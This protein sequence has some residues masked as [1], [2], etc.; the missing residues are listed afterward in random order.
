MA[1]SLKDAETDR[2]A[3]EVTKLTGE[4]LAEGAAKPLDELAKECVAMATSA[5]AAILL[6]KPER[7]AFG[8]RMEGSPTHL[9]SAA[10]RGLVVASPAFV[11]IASTLPDENTTG[12]ADHSRADLGGARARTVRRRGAGGPSPC[13]E[14]TGAGRAAVR[15]GLSRRRGHRFRQFGSS[16]RSRAGR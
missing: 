10:F 16:M 14:G 11:G 2:P 6:D 9:V 7:A 3:R 5:I 4:S 12:P 1:L 8:R 13:D 15:R